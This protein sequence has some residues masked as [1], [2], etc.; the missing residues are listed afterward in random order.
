MWTDTDKQGRT[1]TD[2]DRQGRTLADRDG[3]ERT[4]MDRDGQG[5]TRTN[6]ISISFDFRQS[7]IELSLKEI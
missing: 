4:G 2:T 1:W 3:H 5:Q 6:E 7:K